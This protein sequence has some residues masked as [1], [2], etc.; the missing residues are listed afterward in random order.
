MGQV[1]TRILVRE[2]VSNRIS[3]QQALYVCQ[4]KLDKLNLN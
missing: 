2:E 1:V 3:Y 4:R